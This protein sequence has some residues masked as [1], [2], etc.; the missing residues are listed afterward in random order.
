MHQCGSVDNAPTAPLATTTSRTHLCFGALGDVD[1]YKNSSSPASRSSTMNSSPRFPYELRHTGSAT[2]T[3]GRI[4]FDHRRRTSC[5]TRLLCRGTS[6]PVVMSSCDCH[7]FA[8]GKN[9]FDN[10]VLVR[11][12]LIEA[13]VVDSWQR[14]QARRRQRQS[15]V[16]CAR[17]RFDHT[18][19]SPSS[20]HPVLAATGR[21]RR[22][23]RTRAVAVR[24]RQCQHSDERRHASNGALEHAPMLSYIEWLNQAGVRVAI[25]RALRCARRETMVESD[26]RSVRTVVPNNL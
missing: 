5:S 3:K 15:A 12:K 22:S 9:E 14:S 4:G 13:K 10:V 19:T 6:L 16:D 26:A 1:L 24:Q 17:N 8:R 20:A 7:L 21:T 23:R 2:L 18:V 25:A 11:T